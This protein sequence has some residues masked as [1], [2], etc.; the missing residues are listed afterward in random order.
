MTDF[1]RTLA[2]KSNYAAF[3]HIGMLRPHNE[4]AW[5][6]S[7]KIATGKAIYVISDGMGGANAGEVASQIAVS[8]VITFFTKKYSIKDTSQLLKNSIHEAHHEIVQFAKKNPKTVGMG[9]TLVLLWID[10]F[11]RPNI[12]WAGDSRCYFYAQSTG[13]QLLT[14]DHSHVQTLVDS[15]KISAEMARLHPQSNVILQCLGT[16]GEPP[17][18]SCI[19]LNEP[20]SEDGFFL[21]CSD[22]LHSMLSDAE[23][24]MKLRN[25]SQQSLEYA[26]SNLINAA[27]EAGGA[28]NIT[29]VLVPAPVVAKSAFTTIN[30]PQ[31]PKKSWILPAILCAIVGGS[32]LFWEL[33]RTKTSTTVF[34]SP[35]IET[36]SNLVTPTIKNEPEAPSSNESKKEQPLEQKEGT[37]APKE[38]KLGP[39]ATPIVPKNEAIQKTIDS[40]KNQIKPIDT[41]QKSLELTPIN[42]QK[43]LKEPIKNILQQDTT[44]K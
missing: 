18:S 23:I 36:P 9:C 10:D 20:P 37:K 32:L 15:G 42:P 12:A 30:S 5:A 2:Q 6:C 7:E 11:N 24:E 29:V 44:Q 31:K 19:S 34:N 43:A 28:D 27:N 25:S 14:K 26:A 1:N 3:S 39:T 21:L 33:T 16:P 17:I 41:L 38:S 13:L 40:L 8:S 22:G 4:D 35:K